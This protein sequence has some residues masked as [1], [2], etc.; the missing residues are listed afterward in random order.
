MSYLLTLLPHDLPGKSVCKDE[1]DLSI[2]RLASDLV[3]VLVEV[4]PDRSATPDLILVGHSMVS[5]VSDGYCA[6][7]DSVVRRAVRSWSKHAL[8]YKNELAM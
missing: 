4:F 1:G 3:S 8:V 5:I 7:A 2:D 6:A